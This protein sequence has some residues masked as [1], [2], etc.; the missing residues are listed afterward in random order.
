MNNK[1]NVDS[2][3]LCEL[4]PWY[5]NDTLADSER[6]QLERH[7]RHC[8]KCRQEL[9]VLLGI[10]RCM[11]DES[12]TVLMPPPNVEKFLA[13]IGNGDG[14]RYTNR[15]VWVAGSIAASILL[16]V[17]AFFWL[18]SD[19]STTTPTQFQ[20]ATSAGSEQS[21]DYVLLVALDENVE[22]GEQLSVLH[23]YNP[24]SIAGPDSLGKYR[25]VVRLPARSMEALEDY[26]QS[27]ESNS[28][29]SSVAV[30]ALELPMESR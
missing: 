14:F 4:L 15:N 6:R 3:V 26:R 18:Q 11:R 16:T 29:I 9:P 13:E 22:A 1:H 7:L 20:T 12:V 23:S 2:D 25:V 21:F 27:I 17:F 8:Q 30:V 24:L 5:V 19:N 10:Q 28:K